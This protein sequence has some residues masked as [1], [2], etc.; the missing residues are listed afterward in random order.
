[1][2]LDKHMVDLILYLPDFTMHANR[3]IIAT[4][5]PT[6]TKYNPRTL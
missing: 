3:T 4:T 5:K 6:A 1:M 2:S